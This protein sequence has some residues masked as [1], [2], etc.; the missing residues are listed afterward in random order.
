[1]KLKKLWLHINGANRIIVCDP[2]KDSLSDMLRHIGLTS[3]KVGCNTGV[4][5]SCSI[6]LNGKVVS[7]ASKN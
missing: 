4:C 3:V 7:H 5:G 1:M 2:E 6:L